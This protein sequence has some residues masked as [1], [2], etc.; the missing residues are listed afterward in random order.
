MVILLN[1]ILTQRTLSENN[2]ATGLPQFKMSVTVPYSPF[3]IGS[4]L[5]ARFTRLDVSLDITLILSNN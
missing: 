2:Y 1:T 3:F 5:S 4:N